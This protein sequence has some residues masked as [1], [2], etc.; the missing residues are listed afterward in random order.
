[1]PI[2]CP[3]CHKPLF[4]EIV[5]TRIFSVE[6]ILVTDVRIGEQVDDKLEYVLKCMDC[7]F[8]GWVDKYHHEMSGARSLID[9]DGKITCTCLKQ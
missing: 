9:K 4:V 2:E 3:R 7:K 1:M 5:S 8:S 6:E